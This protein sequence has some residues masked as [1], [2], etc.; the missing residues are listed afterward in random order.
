[1][2]AASLNLGEG[3]APTWGGAGQGQLY[4]DSADGQLHYLRS[5][6]GA[7]V[8]PIT[9]SGGGGTVGPSNVIFVEDGGNDLTGVR[10]D[11]SKPFASLQGAF[12]AAGIASGDQIRIGP[13]QFN[14]G[15]PLTWPAGVNSLSIVGSGTALDGGTFL[16]ATALVSPLLVPPSNMSALTLANMGLSNNGGACLYAD[17]TGG[18]NTYMDG[19]LYL[20]NLTMSSPSPV[21]LYASLVNRLVVRGIFCPTGGITLNTCVAQDF[22]NVVLNSAAGPLKVGWDDDNADKPFAARAPIPFQAVRGVDILLQKQAAVRF[23]GDCEFSGTIGGDPA[24]P[25]DYA[26]T[27]VAPSIEFYGRAVYARF[28]DGFNSAFPDYPGN[29]LI[30]FTGARFSTSAMFEIAGAAANRQYV[31]GNGLISQSVDCRQGV[32]FFDRY[33]D[34]GTGAYITSGGGTVTPGRW[35]GDVTQSALTVTASFGLT[36]GFAPGY[37]IVTSNDA[38]SGGLVSNTWTQTGVDVTAISAATGK[39]YI[40][41]FWHQTAV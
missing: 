4:F 39:S 16:F 5:D 26:L 19:G 23:A 37:V 11:A 34:A 12:N 18:G 22:I 2:P 14:V 32:D 30:D 27:M 24:S 10:G 38:A 29:V 28:L 33:A 13:G 9:V 20:L 40:A 6:T 8:G 31:R 21:A 15:A 41:A 36:M 25:L 7:S 1:M 17:G 35:T 3:T